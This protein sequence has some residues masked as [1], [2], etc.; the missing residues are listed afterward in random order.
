MIAAMPLFYS[1]FQYFTPKYHQK[2]LGNN[3]G[4]QHPP[5]S[6][7][8]KISIGLVVTMAIVSFLGMLPKFAPF[9]VLSPS[10]LSLPF[11]KFWVLITGTFYHDNLF[12][13]FFYGL[14][15]LLFSKSIEPIMG[16]KEFLR[17]F[18][19]IGLYTNIAVLLF[20]GVMIALT[21][22]LLIAQRPF[23]TNSAP[24]SAYALFLAHEFIDLKIP[25]ICGKANART[26]PFYMFLVTLFMSLIGQCDGLLSS[27]FGNVLMYLY[28]RYIK[29]NGNSRGDPSF[30]PTKLLPSC[31]MSTTDD[32]DDSDG[33][34]NNNNPGMFQG[35]PMFAGQQPDM[36]HSGPEGGISRFQL[37]NNP[38]PRRQRQGGNQGRTNHFQGRARTLAD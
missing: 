36:Q 27:L 31:D 14:M 12:F 10:A 5:H 6:T 28:L 20:A 18:I 32:S 24:F 25:T 13:G 11:P 3:D 1:L 17:I 34:P 19:M 35:G 2:M 16:S 22:N 33:G 30:S 37:D 15:F 23:I 21:G 4:G 9:I 38:E 29:K 26:I 7:T 8:T